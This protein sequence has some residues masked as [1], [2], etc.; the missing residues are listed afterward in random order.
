MKKEMVLG[1]TILV[2]VM[3]S[4]CNKY[5]PEKDFTVEPFDG[6][7]SVV[8]T[9]YVGTNWEVRIPSKIRKLPVTH[10]GE[11]AFSEKNLTSVTIP[12]SVTNI[13]NH[14][15]MN[16]QLTTITIPKSVIYLSGFTGNRLTSITIPSSVTNIGFQAF[17][18][19][20]LTSVNI[21]DSVLHIEDYAFMDNQ[22]TNVT[23]PG[24]V[25]YIGENAFGKNPI[26]EDFE[27]VI[28]DLKIVITKFK[29][30]GGPVDNIPEEIIGLPVTTIGS[31]AFENSQATSV[32]IPN[33]ITS[34][35]E[36]A[37]IN[38]NQLHSV[39]IP[40]S[41]ISIERRAF[42]SNQLTSVIIPNS[43]TSIAE[44]A[45]NDN[46]LANIT[47]P[48]SVT[49]IEGGTFDQNEIISVTIGANVP[50]NGMFEI[51][52]LHDDN[53]SFF[54]GR[55][56]G[57]DNGF[58]QT[59]INGGRQAGTYTRLS[60]GYRT[61]T[62][63]LNSGQS[64]V[65]GQNPVISSSFVGTWKRDNFNNTLT[66]TANTVKSSSQSYYWTIV[67]LSNDNTLTINDESRGSYTASLSM[68]LVNG[69]IEI[70]GDSG[71]GDNNWNGT[72][73]RQ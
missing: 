28:H 47:I 2:M 26:I 63:H 12:N 36:E 20:K 46:R 71:N 40:D 38:N 45:F 58:T 62:R 9:G 10:I 31:K 64:A 1:L 66:I 34:I 15:F 17:G 3:V 60:N 73:R 32:I 35:R 21:P 56:S 5:D 57:H 72:W 41:I 53:S 22:L 24:S 49:S 51:S 67:S 54:R 52:V 13:G 18:E 55:I 65:S 42:A 61:W 25:T 69:N 30:F 59:Y 16:N 33:N 11:N 43:V 70:S 68:E 8:I 4:A 6:G 37:F 23:I 14:A 29:G 50:I 27:F 48:S 44:Y 39:T 19:N 7:K